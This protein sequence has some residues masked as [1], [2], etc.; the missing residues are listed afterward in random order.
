MHGSRAV[1]TTRP[2]LHCKH[3]TNDVSIALA[4]TYALIVTDL[5]RVIICQALAVACVDIVPLFFVR[6]ACVHANHTHDVAH[7]IRDGHLEARSGGDHIQLV[8]RREATIGVRPVCCL[9]SSGREL[10]I[11]RTVAVNAMSVLIGGT[12]TVNR[13]ALQAADP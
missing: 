13:P 8:A 4:A 2:D 3:T 11:R 1:E 6:L 9:F 12:C 5:F 7:R 10:F